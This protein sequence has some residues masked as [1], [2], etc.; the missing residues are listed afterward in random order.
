MR[1]LKLTTQDNSLNL[2]SKSTLTG[3]PIMCMSLD[4]NEKLEKL[5]E[6]E[7]T[8]QSLFMKVDDQSL[9]LRD[10]DRVKAINKPI[11]ISLECG[12]LLGEV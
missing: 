2:S 8:N 5:W 9:I 3:N 7:G 6:Y 4:T 1:I 10:N 11:N 12:T